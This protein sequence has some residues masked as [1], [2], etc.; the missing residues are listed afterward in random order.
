MGCSGMDV[1]LLMLPTACK[2]ALSNADLHHC[3]CCSVWGVHS[4]IDATVVQF[5][6][7]TAALQRYLYPP[8]EFSTL[9]VI[10]AAL[11]NDPFD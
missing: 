7:E 3:Y 2:P 9:V 5:A 6:F 8:D 1:S 11:E 4:P 10:V